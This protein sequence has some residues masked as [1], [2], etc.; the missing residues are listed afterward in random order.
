MTYRSLEQ[1]I[2]PGNRPTQIHSTEFWEKRKGNSV[3]KGF[4]TQTTG[5]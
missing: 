2:H 4:G 5:Y 1:N 3:E